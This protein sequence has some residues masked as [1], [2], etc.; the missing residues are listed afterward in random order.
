[1]AGRTRVG[2]AKIAANAAAGWW[3]VR[4]ESQGRGGMGDCSGWGAQ[5]VSGRVCAAHLGRQPPWTTPTV[6]DNPRGGHPR[7]GH[8]PW[9]TTPVVDTPMHDTRTGW[10]QG[11]NGRLLVTGDDLI[12]AAQLTND[13]RSASP[14]PHTHYATGSW[15]PKREW[16]TRTGPGHGSAGTDD[17]QIRQGF[18]SRAGGHIRQC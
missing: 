8:P 11:F 12:L 2:R 1:M 9:T 17:D 10:I 7:G 5:R 16:I 6:D 4:A 18:Q 13:D 14:Q 15:A 3:R